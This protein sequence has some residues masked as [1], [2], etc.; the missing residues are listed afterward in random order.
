MKPEMS[1]DKHWHMTATRVPSAN[2][3]QENKIVFPLRGHWRSIAR[4]I[5]GQADAAAPR[6]RGSKGRNRGCVIAGNKT[7][8]LSMNGKIKIPS[9][10]MLVIVNKDDIR[11]VKTTPKQTIAEIKIGGKIGLPSL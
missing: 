7:A 9:F 6:K 8:I 2:R 3:K 5:L 10:S 11:N 4:V 1:K